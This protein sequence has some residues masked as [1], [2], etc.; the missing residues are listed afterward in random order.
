MKPHDRGGRKEGEG[1]GEG[2]K[3]DYY[4]KKKWSRA[5]IGPSMPTPNLT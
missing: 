4:K 5:K 1:I 2:R 3:E